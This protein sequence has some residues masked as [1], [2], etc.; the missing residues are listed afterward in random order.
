MLHPRPEVAKDAD[1]LQPDLWSAVD[2][3]AALKGALG[4]VDELAALKGALEI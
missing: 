1:H 3:L 4:A 2:E